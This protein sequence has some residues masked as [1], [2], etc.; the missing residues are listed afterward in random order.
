MVDMHSHIIYGIDDGSKSKEMTLE[1][2]KLSIE[3]GVKKIV[4]TPHYMKGRF[5]VEY[6]EVKDKVNELRQMVSEEKLDIEI[7][8][9]QEVYYR[10]NIL[11]YYEEGAIGTI[12]DSRYMLIELPMM[13]FD[14]NSVIDN[15]Y[16]LTL[17]GIIPII[18]HPERYIPFIKNPSLI[19][20]FIKE[21]YLF[22]LNTGSIVG[23]FGKE[24]KKLA[25][26]YLGNGVYYICGSDA[27]SDGRRNTHISKE[28]LEILSN[29]KDEFIK[30]GQLILDD[31]EVKRK[32]NL[33]KERKKLFGIF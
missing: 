6:S 8:C 2:L 24:V 23:D 31:K 16:E 20:D 12:N 13:E 28:C 11:E 9:G 4:A 30:N 25:L 19:N 21:G 5:N 1:M 17:K 26:N 22:Q 7:Y 3:C 32:I 10:E 18:A 27:H 33:I 14:V 15:L 29:Y